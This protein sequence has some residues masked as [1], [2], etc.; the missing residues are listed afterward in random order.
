M[1]V[2]KQ[3]SGWL[4]ICGKSFERW[5]FSHYFVAA[6][7]KQ[8]TLLPQNLRIVVQC[9]AIIRDS[10]ALFLLALVYHDYKFL[11]VGVGCQGRIDD[12]EVFKN[13]LL[14]I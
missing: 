6:D 4:E 3:E 5:D 1:K 8:N 14:S 10:A 13:S 11:A 7:G 12:G 9:T 2:Q